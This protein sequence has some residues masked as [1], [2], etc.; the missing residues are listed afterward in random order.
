MERAEEAP[1]RMNARRDVGSGSS[2]AF[3]SA[4]TSRLQPR[5][6]ELGRSSA[7]QP[8]AQ[9][10]AIQRRPTSVNAAYFRTLEEMEAASTP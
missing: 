4:S 2:R 7:V 8:V 9:Q 10:G 3:R 5:E 6:T 1:R